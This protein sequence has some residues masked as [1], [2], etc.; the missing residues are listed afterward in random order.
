M[1]NDALRPTLVVEFRR[2][3]LEDELVSRGGDR[4]H[5]SRKRNQGEALK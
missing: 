5:R 1:A 3:G 2:E 4:K